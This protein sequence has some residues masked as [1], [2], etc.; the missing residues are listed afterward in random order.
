MSHGKSLPTRRCRQQGSILLHQVQRLYRLVPPI[1]SGKNALE[2]GGQARAFGLR[3]APATGQASPEVVWL[4]E[5]GA[6]QLR[7]APAAEHPDTI[8][9]RGAAPLGRGGRQRSTIRRTLVETSDR[10]RSNTAG[11]RHRIRR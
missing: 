4:D 5:A 7:A 10:G 2:I 9:E 11:R 3:Y 1:G 8:A 6:R